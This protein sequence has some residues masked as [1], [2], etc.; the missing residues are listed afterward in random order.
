MRKDKILPAN[1]CKKPLH[2]FTGCLGPQPGS[3]WRSPRRRTHS[4]WAAHDG[5]PSPDSAELLPGVQRE[6]LCYSLSLV[7]TLSSTEK[8]LAPSSLHLLFGYLQ[9]LMRFSSLE[10]CSSP[11]P[12]WLCLF[13]PFPLHSCLSHIGDP[14]LDTLLQ[15]YWGCV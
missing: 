12:S 10:R 6:P 7:L 5:A 11:R 9:T 3:F 15:P 8:S 13:G 2:R 14:E 4:L 1:W